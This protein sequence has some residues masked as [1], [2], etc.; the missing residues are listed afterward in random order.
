MRLN[1]NS[2]NMM[3]EFSYPAPPDKKFPLSISIFKY[4]SMDIVGR[5]YPGWKT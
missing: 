5:R 4:S 3:N 1:T 2:N